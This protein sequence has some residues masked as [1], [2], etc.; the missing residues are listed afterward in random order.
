M[1]RKDKFNDVVLKHREY[2]KNLGV[3]T[4]GIFGSVVRSED[5]DQSDYDILVEFQND[6]KSF[7]AFA[8][9]CDFFDDNLGSN[10][11]IIP[12]ESLSPYIGP[13][14]LQEVE[15]VKIGD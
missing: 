11:E 1:T 4:I 14:I 12:K 3:S 15:Y 10:Y 9:L 13:R 6:R 5:T 8:S 2:L 7:R